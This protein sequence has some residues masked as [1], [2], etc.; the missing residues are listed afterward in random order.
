MPAANLRAGNGVFGDLFLNV[1][2]SPELVTHTTWESWD[3][4]L[5]TKE[6][7]FKEWSTSSSAY[8]QITLSDAWGLFSVWINKKAMRF[9]Q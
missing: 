3:I 9:E 7:F 6:G 1:R 8:R 5:T 4:P 2:F